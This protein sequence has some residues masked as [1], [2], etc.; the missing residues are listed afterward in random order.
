MEFY[1][2]NKKTIETTAIAVVGA[3]VVVGIVTV[4]K[5]GIVDP[6]TVAA[7]WMLERNGLPNMDLVYVSG[8]VATKVLTI[9]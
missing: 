1:K 2:R 9:A 4:V 7:A 6:K 8:R 3:T 5:V